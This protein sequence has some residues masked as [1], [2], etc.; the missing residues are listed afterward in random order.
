ML[1][2]TRPR[3]FGES[4]LISKFHN[5]FGDKRIILLGINFLIEEKNISDYIVG[6][7]YGI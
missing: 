1:L 5:I 7:R 6:D 4:L 2:F 3:G